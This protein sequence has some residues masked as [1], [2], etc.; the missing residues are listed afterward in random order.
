M[1]NIKVDG[2]QIVCTRTVTLEKV[3]G[4]AAQTL[5]STIKVNLGIDMKTPMGKE[6]AQRFKSTFDDRVNGE[7]RK[8]DDKFTRARLLLAKMLK[9]GDNE[10]KIKNFADTQQESLVKDWNAF[11]GRYAER[12]AR[13]TLGDCAKAIGKE[14]E[15]EFKALKI[16][17][18]SEE[19]KD[20]RVNFLTGVLG[21]VGAGAATMASTGGVGAII[22]M[23]SGAGALIGTSVAIW[24]GNDKYFKQSQMDATGLAGDVAKIS[25]AL[26]SSLA[27]ISRIEKLRVATRA[28]IVQATISSQKAGDTLVKAMRAAVKGKD[29]RQVRVIDAARRQ[30]TGAKAEALSLRESIVETDEINKLLL[31][32]KRLIDRAEVLARNTAGNAGE[33]ADKAKGILKDLKTGASALST[34]VSRIRT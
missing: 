28:R 27:R 22:P 26:D 16:K 15:A 18:D 33:G 6:L 5:S 19:M 17:F 2:K 11:H 29:Q 8:L 23:I 24:D 3:G 30:V 4:I 21:I 7:A 1:F 9:D 14:A 20:N 13:D 31:D 32:A 25:K 34:L 12:I 10:A